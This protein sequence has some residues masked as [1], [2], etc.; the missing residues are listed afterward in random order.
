MSAARGASFHAW[1]RRPFRAV[2]GEPSDAISGRSRSRSRAPLLALARLLSALLLCV[3]AT[4]ALSDGAAPA[5]SSPSGAPVV[6]SPVQAVA[7]LD[8]VLEERILA[9]DPDH[10]SAADIT[11]VLSHAPA[12]RII[13][14]QGSVPL[15]TMQPFAEF[16]IAMGYPRERLADPRDDAL[17][18]PSS[19]SSTELAGTVAWYYEAEGLTPMLIGHSQGGM[20]AIKVLHELAGSFSDEVDVWNPLTDTSEHRTWIRDPRS[21]NIRPVVGLRLP[22]VAALAT[23]KLPRLLLG[24]W[25]MLKKVREVPDSVEEFS[26]YTIEWDP[27]AGT[28]PGS[29][30]YKATGLANVRNITLDSSTSHI[31]M[32]RARALAQDKAT[33]AWIDAYRVDEQAP[34]PEHTA[35]DTSNLRHAA[36]IWFS[37]KKHWCMELQRSIRARRSRVAAGA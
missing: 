35:A 34:L 4:A 28:F 13:L 5:S 9:L 26:G 29:E 15:V 23:G 24:Q 12:P 2:S 25:S 32:P 33:R 14:L 31:G 6:A 10:I 19:G 16:L 30:A 21:G 8:V 7:A 3:A 1:K 20:L 22:Y 37:V 11:G 18:M 27:I 17:S 36:D